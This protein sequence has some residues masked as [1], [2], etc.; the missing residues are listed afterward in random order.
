MK[1]PS[2]PSPT[3]TRA[4]MTGVG[5][6][7]EAIESAGD[8]RRMRMCRLLPETQAKAAPPGVLGAGSLDSGTPM[9]QKANRVRFSDAQIHVEE[10]ATTCVPARR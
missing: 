3:E 10:Q 9:Q 7:A 1:K 5:Q 6:F 4:L 2:I 8:A